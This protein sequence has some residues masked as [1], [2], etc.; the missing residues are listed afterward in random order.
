[1]KAKIKLLQSINIEDLYDFIPEDPDNFSFL[2]ELMIGP[3]DAPGE[4]SFD[5][6]V[7]TPKWLASNMKNED[8]LFGNHLLIVLE[9]NFAKILNKIERY[10]RACKGN[11]WNEIASKLAR[12]FH[13]EFEGYN[14]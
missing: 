3:A 14:E 7:C 12:M 13:W 10:V 4:E 8:V 2:L 9:Y 1:M 11:N 6:Q 5:I